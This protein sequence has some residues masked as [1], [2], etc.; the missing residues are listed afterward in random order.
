MA[1]AASGGI[2]PL[3]KRLTLPS[4]VAQANAA[5]ALWSLAQDSDNQVIVFWPTPKGASSLGRHHN[6]CSTGSV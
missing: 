3:V 4:A 5:G 2:L 1:I 6:M